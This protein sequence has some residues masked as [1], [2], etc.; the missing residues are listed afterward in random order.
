MV[1]PVSTVPRVF[2]SYTG[3]DQQLVEALREGLERDDTAKC[4]TFER[5]IRVSHNIVEKVREELSRCTHLLCVVTPDSLNR[6]WIRYEINTALLRYLHGECTIFLVL[7]GLE[8][9]ELPWDL[10]QFDH[11]QVV[12]VDTAVIEVEPRSEILS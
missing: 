4:F 12:D 2:V 9:T 5:D 7:R 1:Q 6:S 3:A 10:Q 8:G 11:V